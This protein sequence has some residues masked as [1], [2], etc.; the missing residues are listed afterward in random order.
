MYQESLKT[1]EEKKRKEEEEKKWKEELKKK[2]EEELNNKTLVSYPNTA[3][4]QK[5]AK[6]E[7]IHDADLPTFPSCN[8]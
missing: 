2:R 5:L 3:T 1:K 8:A 6:I 7:I 4:Q